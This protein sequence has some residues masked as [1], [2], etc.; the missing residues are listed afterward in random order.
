M[1]K[2]LF[3]FL[4]YISYIR[5]QC[6]QVK[7]DEDL[8]KDL[9]EKFENEEDIVLS[10]G[11]FQNKNDKD[12][13]YISGFEC[14]EQKDNLTLCENFIAK[15]S[16]L[17]KNNENKIV[18]YEFNEDCTTNR[19]V[20][21]M[22]LKSD[23]FI[24][25]D[26]TDSYNLM[27]KYINGLVFYLLNSYE[28][29]LFPLND[30]NDGED[31]LWTNNVG[32]LISQ[33]NIMYSFP[34]K[35]NLEKEENEEIIQNSIRGFFKFFKQIFFQAKKCYD[36]NAD[37]RKLK[38]EGLVNALTVDK[39]PESNSNTVRWVLDNVEGNEHYKHQI[40]MKFYVVAH[41]MNEIIYGQQALLTLGKLLDDDQE[42]NMVLTNKK[43]IKAFE[44]YFFTDLENAK[45]SLIGRLLVRLI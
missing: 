12:P 8:N 22:K 40:V 11:L 30:E 34:Y 41:C 24:K 38:N 17:L 16:I 37:F 20:I 31:K 33:D 42:K 27:M 39:F 13:E 7:T 1:K 2:L 6:I 19:Y 26:L 10:D 44:K 5:N 21:A 14:T 35:L 43:E 29:N 4:F 32:Y 45:K 28:T 25:V 3:L 23:I 18:C 36:I 9:K 15:Y